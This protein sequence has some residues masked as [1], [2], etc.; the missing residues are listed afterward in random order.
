M[1][2]PQQ[3][4]PQGMMTPA[5]DSWAAS[6]SS[7]EHEHLPIGQEQPQGHVESTVVLP[8]DSHAQ[9]AA[10]VGTLPKSVL[11]QWQLQ[12]TARPTTPHTVV[13]LVHPSGR[14]VWLPYQPDWTTVHMLRAELAARWGICPE[15]LRIVSQSAPLPLMGYVHALCEPGEILVVL[16]RRPSMH[17]HEPPHGD[18]VAMCLT[19]LAP[20]VGPLTLAQEEEVAD[21][22]PSDLSNGQGL[23]VGMHHP[24]LTNSPQHMMVSG[25][26]TPLSPGIRP[27]V[28]AATQGQGQYTVLLTQNA[29]PAWAQTTLEEKLQFASQNVFK[30]IGQ[31]KACTE[32]Q[33]DLEGA[34]QQ[35]VDCSCVFQAIENELPELMLHPAGNYLVSRCFDFCPRLIETACEIICRSIRQ[36]CLHKHGSYV[37]E[38]I[39][40]HGAT[41]PT[42]RCS[43]IA[44]LISP[45]HR[46]H[47]AAH[48][49]GNFVLQKAITQSPESLLP[50]V[51]ETVRSVSG[52]TAHSQKMQK[53]LDQRMQRS[54]NLDPRG[55]DSK[56]HRATSSGVHHYPDTPIEEYALPNTDPADISSRGMRVR[57]GARQLDGSYFPCDSSSMSPVMPQCDLAYD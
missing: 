45:Q 35:G 24:M 12:A 56:S 38:N 13:G 53:K 54:P 21:P 11:C 55:H 10:E 15:D 2:A 37:V 47:I 49:S 19:D 14:M 20:D 28:N 43:L 16:P 48:D 29:P 34:M 26:C 7:S 30:I 17:L 3:Q 1:A 46:A 31:T 40:E 4:V 9:D 42:A 8:V 44:Q 18:A 25:P 5:K 36:Y 22:V 39:I 52:Y 57:P 6:C 51:I 50:L 23:P 32:L 27:S 33:Q 41:S